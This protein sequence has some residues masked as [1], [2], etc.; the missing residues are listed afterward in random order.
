MFADALE[1]LDWNPVPPRSDSSRSSVS[2]SETP[3]PSNDTSDGNANSY[4]RFYPH[5]LELASNPRRYYSHHS[6]ALINATVTRSYSFVNSAHSLVG[7]L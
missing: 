7:F 5:S 1:E 2:S 4:V 3:A 6:V